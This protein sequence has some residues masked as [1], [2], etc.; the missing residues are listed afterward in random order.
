MTKRVGDYELGAILGQGAFGIVRSAINVITK[1]EFAIKIID[2][3]KI[4]REELIESLKK[5]IHILMIINHPN[6]VKL[7]EVLA[8]KTKIYLVL[9]WIKGGELFDVIR[10]NKYIQEPQMRKYFRQ[11]I[12]AIRYCQ[13][14]SIAHRDL[15]PENILICNQTDQIKVNDFGLSSLFQD[16]SNLNNELYTTCGTV[17]YLA[18]E[19]IQSSGYDGHK[20]DIWSLGVILYFSCAGYLPFEDDNVAILLDNIITAQY[21]PFPKYFSTELKD[22]L[23]K[24]LVTH[25]NKRITIDNIIQHSWFQTDISKEEQQWFL[26][27]EFP[28]QPQEFSHHQ[29]T[30]STTILKSNLLENP[31]YIRQMKGLELISFLTGKVVSQLPNPK[32]QSNSE[33]CLT[34]KGQPEYIIKNVMEYFLVKKPI[35][36]KQI[37]TKDTLK[38]IIIF[39]FKSEIKISLEILWL[40]NDKFLLNLQLLEGSSDIYNVFLKQTVFELS[41]LKC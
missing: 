34:I 20:A 1:Q 39:R 27:D 36:I 4:K 13:S 23:S 19:V 28:T 18:P 8:S 16:P 26:Q 17:H 14:K 9:E 25:P 22:L 6:I 24:L 10:N 29:L 35:S 37:Q 3:E 12:R 11:I 41:N 15:K 31:S 21:F 2:K 30:V 38:I 33:S 5:E 32:N 40:I 7:I